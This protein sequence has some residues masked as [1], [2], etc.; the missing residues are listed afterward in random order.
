MKPRK[1]GEYHHGDLRRALL[2]AAIETIEEEGHRTFSLRRLAHRLN[3]SHAAVYRH[4]RGR[5]ALLAAVAQEGLQRLATAMQRTLDEPATIEE[6]LVRFGVE[7]V[8]FGLDNPGL[9]QAIFHAVTQQDEPTKL[10]VDRVFAIPF[11]LMQEEPSAAQ[12][13]TQDAREL[14]RGIWAIVHGWLDLYL[15]GQFDDTTDEEIL[16]RSRHLLE[17]FVQGLFEQA[18]GGEPAV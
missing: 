12:I 2:A 1:A 8:R 7:Y 15:R 14:A 3:V 5:D 13:L 18:Q 9:Y 4:F 10:E 11:E 6:I 17:A 16:T